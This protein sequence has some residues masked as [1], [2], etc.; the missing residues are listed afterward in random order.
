MIQ[1]V[2]ST[3]IGIF[4]NDE[5]KEQ[6]TFYVENE[7]NGAHSAEQKFTFKANSTQDRN[8][9]ILSLKSSIIDIKFAQINNI[10]SQSTPKD[11]QV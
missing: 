1:I 3:E 9:W 7:K 8:D 2:A 11:L 10:S 4:N 5:D 6:L